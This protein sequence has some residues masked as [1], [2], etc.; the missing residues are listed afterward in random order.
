MKGQYLL[1][2]CSIK[3]YSVIYVSWALDW[4]KGPPGSHTGVSVALS[5]LVGPD[6]RTMHLITPRR[7]VIIAVSQGELP[8]QSLTDKTTEWLACNG[9]S[10]CRRE[11]TVLSR[12]TPN[13]QEN[14]QKIW[15]R[16]RQRKGLF[17]ALQFVQVHLYKIENKYFLQFYLIL[18]VFSTEFCETR[19]LNILNIHP[20][21]TVINLGQ[22]VFNFKGL[23]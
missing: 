17:C 15:M 9:D 18:I 19:A 12:K 5:A 21:P 16:E 11:R 2:V 1:Q 14:P 10:Y 22:S 4:Q 13:E 3:I 6:R 23:L 8:Y 20:P 7:L